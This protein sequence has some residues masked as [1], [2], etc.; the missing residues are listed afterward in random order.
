M[1]WHS[2]EAYLMLRYDVT[3]IQEQ[4]HTLIPESQKLLSSYGN[5]REQPGAPGCN[6]SGCR[7]TCSCGCTECRTACSGGTAEG[8][9]FLLRHRPSR[10]V[11]E[12]LRCGL[13]R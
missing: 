1:P 8:D 4:K 2:G 6:P 11:G 9:A 3:D 5:I 13:L 12:C 7:G 10:V